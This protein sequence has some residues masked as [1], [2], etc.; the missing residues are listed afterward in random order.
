VI[1]L[2]LALPALATPGFDPSA[3][4]ATFTED[5]TY[6]QPGE[7]KL[8]SRVERIEDPD[9]ALFHQEQFSTATAWPESAD[10]APWIEQCFG[11][12][13]PLSSAALL[14]MGLN[15]TVAHG[16][17]ILMVPGAGDNGVRAYVTMATRLDRDL[18]P[19]YALTFAHPHGDVY[20]QAEIVADA[21]ARIKARTGA[22]QVDV[23][24]HSKGGIALAVYLSNDGSSWDGGAYDAVGT[25]YRGDVRRAVF[26][27]TPL[28]GIDTAFR[29]TAGNL[30]SLDRDSSL[31]PTS[32][33]AYYPYTTANPYVRTSLEDQYI[34]GTG[35][36]FFPGQRQILAR[37]DDRY[38]LPGSQASLG[39]YALQPDWYTTYEG[40]LGFESSS[41]GIDVA[42]AEGGDLIG[43]LHEHGADPS[44]E[45]YLLAGENPLMPNGSQ[46]WLTD[47]FGETWADTLGTRID[48]WSELAAMLVGD[49]LKSVGITAQEV[50]GL[51]AGDMIL[52][53]ISGPSDGLVFVDSATDRAA[54]TGR[55]AV[56]QQSKVV[57]LSHIDLLYASPV[58]GELLQEAAAEDASQAWMASLGARYTEA[59]TLG[60]VEGVLA[61]DAS[62]GDTGGGDTGGTDTAGGTDTSG[63]TAGDTASDTDTGGGADTAAADGTDGAGGCGRCSG[64]PAPAAAGW[65]LLLGLG[66]A[67]RRRRPGGPRSG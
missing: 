2:L 49:T 54:L 51:A 41:E 40:G 44:V 56:V 64:A 63:D 34:G 39:A 5:E 3:P 1:L 10:W 62:S 53:E 36:D 27:A 31:S 4:A 50:Q 19:V 42:V 43:K 48:Q 32:W 57:N 60:W 20:E 26:I 47:A 33:T 17:P 7:L 37:W 30:A 35:L 61:D 15:E 38:A 52:G 29:W 12:A 6:D 55:G 23:V 14:H 13:T 11:T 21:I 65:G 18:R 28:G 22:D 46:Q 24:A 25:H 66:A 16:T 59:D 9:R 8:W 45:L 67:L 58:T